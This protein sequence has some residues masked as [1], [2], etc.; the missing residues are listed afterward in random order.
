[1]NSYTIDYEKKEYKALIS[2]KQARDYL[3][4]VCKITGS[5]NVSFSVSFIS[6][7]TMHAL[8]K[9]YRG[10]DNSTDILS[11]A[12]LDQKDDSDFIVVNEDKTNLG[13]M[14]I[15]PEVYKRNAVE[16]K[17]P[18]SEE[19]YRLLTHGVLHLTGMDHKTND[20]SEPMLKL[21]ES[22]LAQLFDKASTI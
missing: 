12:A 2:P 5:K 16:F 4:K 18:E 19:L 20:A 3:N 14:L 15:C 21:Q 1:M 17:V 7:E 13:D 6:E 11:F 9:E 8:N 22:I 10:I